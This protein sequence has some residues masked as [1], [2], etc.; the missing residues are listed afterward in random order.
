M[1]LLAVQTGETIWQ[2]PAR[3]E[4]LA[5]VPLSD[6][7][8]HAIRRIGKQL[9]PHEPTVIFAPAEQTE[10][11]TAGLLAGELSLKVRTVEDLAELDFGLWQ[12]LTLAEVRRRQP[13]LHKQWHEAPSSVRPPGGETLEEAYARIE[14]ALATIVRQAKK[15]E[16]VVVLRPVAMG[17]L[18]CRLDQVALDRIWDGMK[19][20]CQWVRYEIDPKNY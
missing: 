13:K 14:R 2:E 18:R 15:Q 10:Q 3:L 1:E 9:V 19:E 7:G 20:G 12:G 8:R 6:K 11:E 17:L 4:N 5:G 16:P